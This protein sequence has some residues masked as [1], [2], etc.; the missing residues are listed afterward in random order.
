[1]WQATTC[2]GDERPACSLRHALCGMNSGRANQSLARG[3]NEGPLAEAS[4][5]IHAAP[6]PAPWHLP[7]ATHTLHPTPAATG[8]ALEP[9]WPHQTRLLAIAVRSSDKGSRDARR[10]QHGTRKRSSHSTARGGVPPA[11]GAL[12]KGVARRLA[13]VSAITVPRVG[14]RRCWFGGRGRRQ[15]QCGC[16]RSGG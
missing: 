15:P 13:E 6:P 1:M 7:A 8:P 9:R 14:C 2:Q 4:G 12:T 3:L 11:R 16:G 5:P 10:R